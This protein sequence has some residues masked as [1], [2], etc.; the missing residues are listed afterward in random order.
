MMRCSSCMSL[1]FGSGRLAIYSAICSCTFIESVPGS[2]AETPGYLPSRSG[3]MFSSII[4]FYLRRAGFYVAVTFVVGN[5]DTVRADLALGHL[6]GCRNRAT[7]EQTF[8]LAQRYRQYHEM[9]RVDKI[10]SKERLQH[11]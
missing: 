4:L 5:E 10:I 7:G 1:R 8:S 11:I 9:K 6:E 2:C 3:E